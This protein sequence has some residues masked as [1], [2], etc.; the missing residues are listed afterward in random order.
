MKIRKGRVGHV[1]MQAAMAILAMI[2]AGCASLPDP[3]SGEAG[4]SPDDELILVFGAS[5][6]SGRYVIE[7]L[8]S[9]G[10]PFRAVTSNVQRAREQVG[11]GY[12][13]VEADV[14]DPQSLDAIFEGV[15]GVISALGAT[16]F[17]GPNGPEFVDYEGVRNVVDAAIRN[18]ARQMVL[19]SAAGVTVPDHP[20]NRM[21]GVMTWKLK[22]EDYLRAS[23]LAYTIVRPGGLLDTDMGQSLV[24]FRQGDDVPY[25]D[26]LSLTSR[27]DLARICIA[28][29]AEPE[30]RFKTFEAFNDA[31]Q[32]GE[33][34]SAS[35]ADLARD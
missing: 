34:R 11:A 31:T 19:I 15:S 33:P 1:D 10:R 17:D 8:Q 4:S 7:E 6:R 5:G 32:P 13:W 3:T 29:L 18:G 27:G 35:F 30:A 21:G 24:V 26:P 16:E 9:A 12:D 25:S 22:G 2:L 14:R 28:A 20:L 23:G